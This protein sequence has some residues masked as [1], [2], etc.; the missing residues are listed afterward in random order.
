MG[1]CCGDP[2]NK[3]VHEELIQAKTDFVKD[4]KLLLLGA[5][6]SGKSTFF[7]QLCQ[8]HGNGFQQQDIEQA[9]QNIFDCIIDQM[10]QLV[11]QCVEN[12]KQQEEDGLND[13]EYEYKL[14]EHAQQAADYMLSPKVP[15]GGIDITPQLATLITTLWSDPSIKKSFETRTNLG[16]V[17][18]APHF[19]EDIDRIS[20]QHYEPTEEDILLVRIPTTGMRS[21]S[22][23]VQNNKFTVVDV[24]GQRN[25]RTKWIH[26]FSIVDAVLFVCSL[27]CYDQNLFEEEDV[28][29]M[30]ESI[31]LFDLV[32]NNRY[33][34]RTSMILFL[35]KNDLFKEKIQHK[36]I[37]PC[38]PEYDGPDYE[39]QPALE[40]IQEIFMSCNP[41]HTGRQIYSHITQATDSDNVAKIF[42]DV[43]HLVV[44]TALQRNGIM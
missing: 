3:K 42:H 9:K 2:T 12:I 32:L 8:I 30:H 15:R 11:E 44:V 43:Q 13:G 18:S 19:F 39:Y 25:E 28:N 36:S 31:R 10:K 40:Y 26:Q 20:D 27:S 41:E 22:F 7:K 17:D 38:F 33:F 34:A 4:H 21:A 23:F 14:S 37:K 35:N 5:G 1:N 6:S 16:V 24:G 29:A